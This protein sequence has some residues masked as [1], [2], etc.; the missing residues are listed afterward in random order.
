MKTHERA[1]VKRRNSKTARLPY[2]AKYFKLGYTLQRIAEKVKDEMGIEKYVKSTVLADIETLK[3]EWRESQTRDTDQAITIEIERN[4]NQMREAWEAWEKSKTDYK[5]KF[6]KQKGELTGKG[7]DGQTIKTRD[8]ERGE[9]DMN[10][11][12]DPRY[13][14]EI[15]MLADQRVKLLGLNAPEKKELTGENGSPLFS[16][17]DEFMD[18]C[19]LQAQEYQ[20]QGNE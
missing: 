9:K 7:P 12:G 6:S 17:F 14:A 2:V 10:A 4:L 18:S 3:K 16:K 5:Q 8:V 11:F 13:L 20:Q 15:R 19:L 1:Y